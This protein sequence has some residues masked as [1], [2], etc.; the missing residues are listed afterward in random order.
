[1]NIR[2]VTI[3]LL[4]L[5]ASI[6]SAATLTLDFNL[7]VNNNGID[8]S[9]PWAQVELAD[10]ATNTVQLTV[11]NLSDIGTTQQFISNLKLNVDPNFA[12]SIS[13]SV[14]S[15][16]KNSFNSFNFSPN[17]HVDAGYTFDVEL[18]F[19]TANPKRIKGGDIY[20]A[21]LTGVGLDAM[22]FNFLSEGGNPNILGL[23]H[24]QS[25]NNGS[26]SKITPNP[27]P[28]PATMLLLAP[29]ALAAYKKR[30]K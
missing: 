8:G 1:M 21:N 9:G 27:V 7:A 26:S 12:G 19:Q 20:V 28:E 3:P 29:L 16:P 14:V 24:I 30:K 23:I 11:K 4:A 17:G 15:D 6:S 5:V 25:S 10:V 18:N 2:I 22:D 13:H